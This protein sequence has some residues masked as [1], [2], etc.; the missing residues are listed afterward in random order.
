MVCGLD[1]ALGYTALSP[2]HP[3][4]TTYISFSRAHM[5]SEVGSN[6]AWNSK[7]VPVTHVHTKGIRTLALG[8]FT[9]LGLVL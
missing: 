9:P 7:H 8:Y 2:S 4:H 5:W 1:M 3:I 6:A